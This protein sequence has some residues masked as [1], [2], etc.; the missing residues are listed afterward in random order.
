MVEA[1]AH[2]HTKTSGFKP[3]DF[4]ATLSSKG[5]KMDEKLLKKIFKDSD[6]DHNGFLDKTEIKNMLK[7]LFTYF[8]DKKDFDSEYDAEKLK[9]K[10]LKEK[11]KMDKK[12]GEDDAEKKDKKVKKDKKED[13]PQYEA[14][15]KAKKELRE[16]DKMERKMKRAEGAGEHFVMTEEFAE[17]LTNF[18]LDVIDLNHDGKVSLDEWLKVGKK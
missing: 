4:E 14:E 13:N 3:E 16:K 6:V 5:H 17:G 18:I 2:P 11:E 10:E 8:D 15:K 7:V 9:K 12:G 1:T